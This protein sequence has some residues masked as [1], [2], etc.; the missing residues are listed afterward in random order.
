MTGKA[1]AAKP[2]CAVAGERFW[3]PAAIG[4]GSAFRQSSLQ[5]ARPGSA[6]RS[7]APPARRAAVRSGWPA[8]GSVAPSA[9]RRRAGRRPQR[10]APPSGAKRKA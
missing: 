8:N 5:A 4:R 6:R 2:P 3:G 1:T 7:A 10:S 9:A